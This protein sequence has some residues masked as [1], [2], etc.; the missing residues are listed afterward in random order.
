MR[1]LYLGFLL[2]AVL[3]CFGCTA[4]QSAES[5]ATAQ[6]EET[7]TPAAE[8][9]DEPASAPAPADIAD[10]TYET[11]VL[12]DGIASPRKELRGRIGDAMI[13]INYGSP[14]VKGRD[15]WGGLVPYGR[16]WRTGANEATSITLSQDVK[17]GDGTL[18]A[19][20]YGFFTIPEDGKCT[21]IFNENAEQWGSG[22]YEEG[23][24]VLRVEVNTEEAAEASETMEFM[25]EGDKIVLVWDKLSI[26]FK[27]SG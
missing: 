22:S 26:P 18:P 12:K 23:K 17:V 2:T 8:P 9:Q 11:S 20:T 3:G 7:E 27:V 25:I 6:T 4:N 19:G 15:I 16:V 10:G 5:N 14:S 13:T 1:D 24:D 21:V